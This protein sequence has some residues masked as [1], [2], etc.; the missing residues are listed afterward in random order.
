LIS[1]FQH[2]PSK[3]AFDPPK[4]YTITLSNR[5]IS[6][7]NSAITIGGQ[8]MQ[9]RMWGKMLLQDTDFLKT[10]LGIG[11]VCYFKRYLPY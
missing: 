3:L 4:V 10:M 1:N 11:D 7:K 8:K 9:K 5:T 6:N 2:T